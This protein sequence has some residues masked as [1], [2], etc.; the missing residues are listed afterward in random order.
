MVCPALLRRLTPFVTL[1][2]LCGAPGVSA[3][4]GSNTM[5]NPYRM[6]EGWATHLAP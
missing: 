2:V 3:Q 1:A 5:H 4:S 6:L